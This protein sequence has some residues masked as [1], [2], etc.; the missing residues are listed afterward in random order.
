MFSLAYYE[1]SS[2]FKN[3]LKKRVLFIKI[4]N[5]EKVQNYLVENKTK[6]R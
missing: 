3:K 4:M 2:F 1:H 6:I 5:K